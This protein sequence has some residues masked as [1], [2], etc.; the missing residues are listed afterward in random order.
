MVTR[1]QEEE[2]IRKAQKQIAAFGELYDIH[3]NTIFGFI[4]KRVR[5]KNLT[6]ELTSLVFMKAMNALRGYKI[7]GA[8]FSSWLIQIALNEVRQ[9][10]RRSSKEVTVPL[11]EVNLQTVYQE[12]DDKQGKQYNMDQLIA[13]MNKLEEIPAT[14]I[15][16]RF[17]EQRSF[18]E[19]GEIMAISTDNAKVRTYRALDK[20]RTLMTKLPHNG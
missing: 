18:K 8:P 4:F 1:Q 12:L 14:Y 17:F 2:L 7:T 5:D 16:L 3:F 10:H 20:L 19:I 15:E 6:A 9:F 11:N 13:C